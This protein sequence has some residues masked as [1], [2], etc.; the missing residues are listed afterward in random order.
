MGGEHPLQQD[1]LSNDSLVAGRNPSAKSEQKLNLDQLENSGKL[2]RATNSAYN[3]PFLNLKFS[4]NSKSGGSIDGQVKKTKSNDSG[5]YNGKNGK[6]K[7]GNLND[8]DDYDQHVCTTNSSNS[9]NYNNNDFDY[10]DNNNSENNKDGT[11]PPTLVRGRSSFNDVLPSQ[12]EQKNDTAT[13]AANKNDLPIPS[14][15]LPSL[16]RKINDFL[17]R[18]IK[19]NKFLKKENTGTSSGSSQTGHIV[20]SAARLTTNNSDVSNNSTFSNNS[21]IENRD[22]NFNDHHY[23]N[24]GGYH[25]DSSS[26]NL[27]FRNRRN[28][29]TPPMVDGCM[30][31]QF[32][33]DPAQFKSY[34]SFIEKKR[35]KRPFMHNKDVDMR[36]RNKMASPMSEKKSKKKLLESGGHNAELDFS[37]RRSKSDNTQPRDCM[38]TGDF[39]SPR[40]ISKCNSNAS[41]I[42]D[43]AYQRV[44]SLDNLILIPQAK[45]T[46]SFVDPSRDVEDL[47]SVIVRDHHHQ[48]GLRSRITCEPLESVEDLLALHRSKNKWRNNADKHSKN[49]GSFDN[50]FFNT[51]NNDINKVKDSHGHHRRHRSEGL[52]GPTNNLNENSNED[53]NKIDK[54]SNG[55]FL[56]NKNIFLQRSNRSLQEECDHPSQGRP[57]GKSLSRSTSAQYPI[58]DHF[59]NDE[60]KGER[61]I[62]S[63]DD[64][65]DGDLIYCSLKMKPFN[66][67]AR[68]NSLTSISDSETLYATEFLIDHIHQPRPKRKSPAS[69]PFL[70]RK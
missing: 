27:M 4:D 23:Q 10:M 58:I 54:N 49:N 21:N 1:P 14:R 51:A 41:N 43:P 66:G 24:N 56:G 47:Y 50:S 36:Y 62:E 69:I 30:S 5:K 16:P 12:L 59:S 3:L 63:D 25:D 18:T 28:L 19:D 7:N 40:K 42:S 26:H 13:S 53:G 33:E 64:Y 38:D 29:E 70:I 55:T 17:E 57:L 61:D 34:G 44:S 60:S 20:N 65:D 31:P 22:N 39:Q 68:R 48:R 9:N 6:K 11:D 37:L 45:N 32:I 15:P 52:S 2:K 35:R 46:T 67:V 8:N